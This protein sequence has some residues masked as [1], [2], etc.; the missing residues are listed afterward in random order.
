MKR[1][2]FFALTLVVGVG[3]AFANT[4]LNAVKTTATSYT[5]YLEDACDSPVVCDS[6]N[7]GPV[8]AEAF[9]GSVVYDTPGCEVAVR[10]VT[11]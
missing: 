11:L 9:S 8:C 5:Y 1:V 7:D 10:Y 4:Q 2:V 3:G 6:A